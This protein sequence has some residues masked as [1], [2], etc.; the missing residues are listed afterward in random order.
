MLTTVISQKVH[1]YI[2]IY[3]FCSSLVNGF[4]DPFPLRVEEGQRRREPCRGPVGDKESL[5][6][7]EYVE[8]HM[9]IGC[10]QGRSHVWYNNDLSGSR[11]IID[12]QVIASNQYQ[13]EDHANTISVEMV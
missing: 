8:V 10:L 2:Y 4:L 9:K 7:H 6:K 3:D 11:T 13:T 12:P 1:I 5:Y